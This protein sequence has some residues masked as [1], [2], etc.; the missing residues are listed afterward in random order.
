MKQIFQDLNKGES[1]IEEV[2]I[3]NLKE[4]EILIK[5]KLSLISA[6]TELS[7]INFS[8]SNYISKAKQQ[9]EKLNQFFEK[10]KADGPKSALEAVKAR[11]DEPLPLGY[12]NVGIVLKVGKNIS[13]F[14]I[15]DRVV[16]N[17]PHAEIV[18][19]SEK[20]CAHI[21]K[22]VKDEDAVFTVLAS[23]GLNGIRLLN[24]TFGEVILISG[25]GLIGIITAKILKANGC[26]VLGI[27][28]DIKRCEFA[29]TF[30]IEVL[31]IS[32]N[33]NAISWCENLTNSN[34]V[35]G[36]II[37]ASTQSNEPIITAAKACRKKGRIVLIGVIGMELERDI[38]YKKELSFQV[39]CSYGP[40]RYDYNYEQN[41]NDYPFPYVRWTEKRNFEAILNAISNNNLNFDKLITSKYKFQEIKSAYSQFKNKELNLGILINYEENIL[42]K[43]TF[44]L[45]N[46]GFKA[47]KSAKKYKE[48]SQGQNISFVGVGNYAKRILIPEFSKAGANL[49]TIC[50]SNGFD[51]VNIGKK[52]GFSKVSTD[53]K[54]LLNDKS[55][56]SVIISTRHDSHGDL[57]SKFLEAGKNVYVEKPLCLNLDE[58][59]QIKSII[60]DN[61]I[62]TVGFNRRFSPFIK[63][64]KNQ[65]NNFEGPYSFIYTCNAGFIEKDHWTQVSK[66]GGGRLIGEACHFIDLLRYLSNSPISEIYSFNAKDNKVCPD[67]F[68]IQINFKNGSI[69]T[70]HYFANGHKSFPK[71]NLQIFSNGKIIHLKNFKSIKSWGLN[72]NFS[73]RKLFQDKGQ[74][75]CVKA[76]LKAIESKEYLPP[77]PYDELFEVQEK[78][79]EVIK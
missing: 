14:K 57:V 77:I 41:C 49:Y 67:T 3:P 73:S 61:Q 22:N 13:N 18:S 9:P 6:G 43:N 66:I 47:L 58:L 51:T 19:V 79:F 52:Y 20:L 32:P 16:S 44:E 5:S 68:T 31:N 30:G 4:N 64:I 63:K 39:S 36:V 28:P 40:G 15:G 76:F 48:S 35:D 59:N 23:I 1:I 38:F 7:L 12:S 75:N 69:G 71:E 26:R 2:P 42:E 25:L 72:N 10:V 34:G 8:K 70:I 21:P 50:S 37:T 74:T 46:S 24:P 55:C 60:S 53:Y 65:L 62:L 11:L 45:A 33:S 29:K 17:G 27:D 78:I 56:D 54:T